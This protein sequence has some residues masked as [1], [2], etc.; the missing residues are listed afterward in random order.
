MGTKLSIHAL[1]NPEIPQKIDCFQAKVAYI[2]NY[3][4]RNAKKWVHIKKLLVLVALIGSCI[5]LFNQ[6]CTAYTIKI[7]AVQPLSG[8]LAVYGEGLKMAI[9]LIVDE[10]N[11]NG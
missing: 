5:F 3:L 10:V 2:N 8:N 9:D 11:S 1:K 7:C 4:E 6:A